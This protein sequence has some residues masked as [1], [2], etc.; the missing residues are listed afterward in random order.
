[1]EILDNN[2]S[3]TASHQLPKGLG[4]DQSDTAVEVDPAPLTLPH[5]A[6]L[7]SGRFA[8]LGFMTTVMAIALKSAV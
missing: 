2:I 1:M 4:V 5:L 8:M 3:V 6:E 7:W